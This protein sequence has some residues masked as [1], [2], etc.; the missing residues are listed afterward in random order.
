MFLS[1]RMNKEQIDQIYI[2]GLGR[3]SQCAEGLTICCY[4]DGPQQRQAYWTAARYNTV[5]GTVRHA[6]IKRI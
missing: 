3:S 1:N 2:L 5:T 4:S 6:F